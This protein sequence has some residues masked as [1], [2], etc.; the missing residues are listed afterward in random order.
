MMLE[1]GVYKTLRD[2]EVGD[3]VQIASVTG[4]LDGFS[5]VVSKPHGDNQISAK[6]VQLMTESKRAV[7]VTAD[8]LVLGGSCESS[9]SLVSAGSVK[10]GQCLQTIAGPEV[11]TAASLA[12]ESGVFTVVTLKG[13][14]LVVNGVVAS[15]FA[16]N[17]LVANAFYNI[18]RAVYNILPSATKQSMVTQVVQAFGELVTGLF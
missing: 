4:E 5:P 2:V 10:V 16:V 14:L 17:H 6:F 1:S 13:G 11:V 7:K 15:P 3:M 9:L 18:H 12:K 8:H